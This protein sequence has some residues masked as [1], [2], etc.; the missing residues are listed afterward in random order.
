MASLD[1]TTLAQQVLT[2]GL[3]SPS[4]LQE[5]LDEVGEFS[6]KGDL[7]L[8]TLERKGYLTRLQIDKLVKGER[9][10]YVLGGYRLLYKIASGTFGRVYRADH[11]ATGRV[12]AVKVLRRRWMDR[13]ASIELFER[14]GRV[15][16]S[17]HHPNIVEILHIGRDPATQQYFIVM[18]FV[19]GGNLRDLL[20]IRKKFEPV[21]ALRLLDDMASALTYAF[22]KGLTHRDIKLTNILISSQGTAKLVDFG[23]ARMYSAFGPSLNDVQVQRTV[24][25]AGL[26][27]ATGVQAGDVRSDIFFL[28][29]VFYEML[30][31]RPPLPPTRDKHVRMQRHR[32]ENIPPLQPEDV[33][34]PASVIRL[35]ETMLA[36]QPERRFQTPAQLQEAVREARAEVE[37]VMPS[38]RGQPRR[39]GA[40][41]STLFVVERDVRLQDALRDKL[42]KLGYR[43]LLA[44]D[45]SRALERFSEQPFDGLI[46]D[47]GTTF[48]EGVQVFQ[49]ILR[50]ARDKGLECRGILILSEDQRAWA[51]AVAT[52]SSAA[53]LTRPLK[54]GQ[55]VTK[56]RE[57]IQ[58]EVP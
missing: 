56:L 33:P 16:M 17:L 55:L 29:C 53:V 27:K 30:T 20:S 54:M 37:G 51:S 24:D 38:P 8:R 31:G 1:A 32:F 2:L 5:C 9:D 28:G 57:L 49:R 41:A 3:V 36:F 40:S 12:V 50:H 42:K 22:A 7:L 45:P 11:P 18:E 25:Y 46:V 48:Q 19:E 10:G 6:D 13:Q 21:D 4:Q 44:G 14:E 34:G 43:V 52:Q 26:E 23:L 15:G 39:S 58:V 47:A 35:A